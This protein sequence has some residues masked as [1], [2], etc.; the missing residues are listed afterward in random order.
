MS[1]I[2]LVSRRSFFGSLT[3]GVAILS[4]TGRSHSQEVLRSW[5]I[6]GALG[7]VDSIPDLDGDGF[8]E[9]VVGRIWYPAPGGPGQVYAI[10]GL[11]GTTLYSYTATTGSELGY[12][13]ATVGDVNGDGFPDFGAG[14][15][16]GMAWLFDGRNGSVLLQRR[17][18]TGSVVSIG[19]VNGDGMGDVL[20][21]G[22]TLSIVPGNGGSASVYLGGSLELFYTIDAPSFARNFGWSSVALGDVDSDGVGDFAIGAP[23]LYG[24]LYSSGYVFVYSGRDGR[25]LHDLLSSACKGEEEFG[26]RLAAPGDLTGDRICDL[27]VGAPKCNG[28]QGPGRLYLFDGRTGDLISMVD[29]PPLYVGL[30]YQ[31]EAVGDVNGNGYGDLILGSLLKYNLNP[32]SASFETWVMDGETR[33]TIFV[34]PAFSTPDPVG[35]N[36]DWNGDDFPD[37]LMRPSKL[38][39]RSGAPTGVSVLGT[40]CPSAADR[41]PRIGATGMAVIGED[42]PVHLSRVRPNVAGFLAVGTAPVTRSAFPGVTGR[43]STC[44]LLVAP[45]TIYPTRTREIRPGEG[46][47]T[48]EIPIQNDPSLQGTTFY[49]QWLVM[50]EEDELSLA[51][52]TRM[53]EIQIQ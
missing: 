48:V 45:T 13:L 7:D 1:N 33:E 51:A 50:D 4:A 34:I 49:A 2:G 46:V 38:E 14:S 42:Y 47:A 24:Q 22:G 12:P 36:I 10:S 20:F 52:S 5:V 30:G 6:Q 15:L 40:A 29:P 3:V 35:N 19:D 23:G 32:Y 9:I 41:I 27:A 26:F 31:V 28:A 18:S 11:A 39:L 37:F 21:S 43:G 17:A 44:P 16:G 25:L 8:R 53:L